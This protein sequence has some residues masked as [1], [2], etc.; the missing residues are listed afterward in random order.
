MKRL[1]AFAVVVALSAL[2]AFSPQ[3][4]GSHG[5]GFS[6]FPFRLFRFAWR[7]FEPTQRILGAAQ[8]LLWPRSRIRTADRAQ[9]TA[10]VSAESEPCHLPRYAGPSQPI[11]HRTPYPG[12][13]VA[14]A[15]VR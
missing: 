14:D 11:S 12:P 8:R 10:A 7:I 1:A 4:G 2:P 9:R 3:R 5:G 15:S 6:R 13:G